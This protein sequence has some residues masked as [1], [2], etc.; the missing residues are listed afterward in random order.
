MSTTKSYIGDGVYAEFD[1]YQIKLSTLEGHAIFL[2]P[3]VMAGLLAYYGRTNDLVI[4]VEPK[5][6]G[7][8][9]S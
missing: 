2:E 5:P 8:N 3:E 6:R 7:P 9:E 4:K 1:G